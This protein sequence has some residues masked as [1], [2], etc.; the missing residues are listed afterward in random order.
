MQ[1][2]IVMMEL[3][4]LAESIS[5]IAFRKRVK[6]GEQLDRLLSTRPILWNRSELERINSSASVDSHKRKLTWSQRLK[7]GQQQLNLS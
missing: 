6:S 2:T 5:R 4:Q 7:E 1:K 3:K